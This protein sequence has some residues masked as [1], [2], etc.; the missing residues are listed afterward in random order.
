MSGN[1][2]TNVAWLLAAIVISI[3]VT[4]LALHASRPLAR[5]IGQ[6]VSSSAITASQVRLL[7]RLLMCG[8]ALVTTQAILRRPVALVVGGDRTSV[9]VEAGIAAG[10]LAAVLLLLVLVYQTARPLVQALTLQAIDAAVP[11]VGTPPETEPTRTSVSVIR[12]PI[13]SPTDA[14]TVVAPLV[15]PRRDP[16]ATVARRRDSEPTLVPRRPEGDATIVT[17]GT[18]DLTQ[19]VHGA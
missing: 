8:L 17:P 11:T 14:V 18:D 3:L 9:P 2:L 7:A 15:L 19:R 13:P 4:V 16:D 10:T 6:R 12:T 1:D 5:A